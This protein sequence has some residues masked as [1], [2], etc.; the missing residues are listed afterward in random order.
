MIRALDTI[1]ADC[2]DALVVVVGPTASG[3]SALAMQ[4]A[5]RLGGEIIGADSV[6]IYRHFDLGSG[7]P[8]VEDRARVTHHLV[9]CVDPLEPFDAA[10]FV[11]L[12]DAAIAMVRA[13]GAIPVLCGGTFLWIKA[14]L[15]G[16]APMP[17][18]DPA[19]R[20][21]HEALARAEGRAALHQR[22]RDVDPVAAAR[23]APNDL[24]RVSRA[25]EVHALTGKTL[26]AWHAEHQFRGERH[27][28]RL[29]GVGRERAELDARIRAR[30]RAWLE[31]G[32]VDEVRSLSS[33]G[34]ERAR[35]MDAVGFKQVRDHLRGEIAADDLEDTIVRATRTFTRRQRTWLR[36]QPITWLDPETA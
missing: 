13:R 34:Y 10:R 33:R 9:D 23:L 31:E 19:V 1:P 28:A 3:K 5:S 30:T 8:S 2:P 25:L 4:I 21:E 18:A 11:T 15:Y 17:G 16:L 32:W 22:L 24:V 12:A 26:T 36:D 20:A 27:P 6:Q 35:A 7:K 29:Y 14:L